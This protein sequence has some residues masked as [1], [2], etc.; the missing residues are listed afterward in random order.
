MVFK[1]SNFFD[2]PQYSPPNTNITQYSPLQTK[3]NDINNESLAVR[4]VATCWKRLPPVFQIFTFSPVARYH[5]YFIKKEGYL[6]EVTCVTSCCTV[7]M[8]LFQIF[9]SHYLSIFRHLL[10]VYCHFMLIVS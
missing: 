8:I 3:A 6:Y 4:L 9:E 5:I 2:L 7:D 1:F 10:L